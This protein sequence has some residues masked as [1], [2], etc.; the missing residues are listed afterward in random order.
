[1][2]ELIEKIANG[3]AILFVGAGFSASAINL[4][5]AKI[6]LAKEL[7]LEISK[8]GGFS[9]TDDLKVSSDYFINK[10]CKD[11]EFLMDE[12]INKLK[13]MY[14]IK[15][16]QEEHISILKLPW[17][18]IYTT[19][20]DDLVEIS[21]RKNN[22][23]IKTVTIDDSTQLNTN[24]NICVHLNGSI[25]SLSKDT[26]NTTFKL[27]SSSYL[28]PESFEKSNWNYIFKQ[29]IE[30]SSAIV[31]IGYSM[32]DIDIEKVLFQIPHLKNRTYFIRRD[33]KNSKNS[34]FEDFKFDKYGRSF[35]VG[36]SGF[37]K[38]V[39]ENMEKVISLQEQFFLESFSKYKIED[40]QVEQIREEDIEIFL[41][42]GNLKKEYIEQGMTDETIPFL[43]RRT[44]IEKLKILVNENKMICV[45]SELGNG[46]SVFLREAA[47]ELA[48]E[49]KQVYVLSDLSGNY[50]ADIDKI[51]SK[52]LS[53]ILIIDTYSNHPDIIKHLSIVDTGNVK[54]LF[55]E[56]TYRHY[57]FISDNSP[58]FKTKDLNIDIL[59]DSEI[60]KLIKIIEHT[61]LWGKYGKYSLGEKRRLLQDKLGSQISNVLIDIF[62]SKHIKDE[63]SKLLEKSI[64][65]NNKK[66][67]DVKKNIFITCLL[68]IMNIPISL[69]LVSDLSQNE[70]ILFTFSSTTEL[71]S[72]FALNLLEQEINTKSSVY[73]LHILKEHFEPNYIIEQCLSVLKDLDKKFSQGRI[74]DYNRNAVRINLFRFNFI[75]QILPNTTKR[76]ML[77]RYFENI[78]NILPYH[79]DNPQYWLQYAMAH[80]AM[81]NYE[82]AE[83]YL[84]TAY[85]KAKFKE[86]YDEYKIDNQ[87]ARL[88]LKKASIHSTTISDAMRLFI[89][90]DTL[91]N[92]L[93]NNI[94]KFKV[95]MDYK[96]FIDSRQK[97]FSHK[98]KTII[99][100]AC[101]IK[102]KDIE[103]LQK[104]DKNNFKQEKVYQQCKSWLEKIVED[105]GSI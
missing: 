19:N 21:S 70:E 48:L 22:K 57:Q 104:I 97:S 20:Y 55:S 75:E 12:L 92:K 53:C 26:L 5:D 16:P 42:Y 34:E 37:A 23:L 80:I 13:H 51:I 15:E 44:K 66:E 10:C 7:S 72:I 94:Y 90:A 31:F 76:E 81:N 96:D 29:D 54:F 25:S 88:N 27:T 60:E 43:I 98:N 86:F 69:S 83:R 38:I 3:R 65:K 50:I 85:D 73:S 45:T 89:E 82:K 105:L 61:T 9:E 91:L 67:E 74:L 49:G 33:N 2:N 4:Y 93:D 39:E 47:L 18:R 36:L 99:L 46:K 30:F 17:K 102:L 95:I 87:K 100:K 8:I 41:K 59:D 11:N 63:I 103:S 68:D 14:T 52:K 78:K 56:R 62:N 64:I 40:N 58:E 79:I 35:K 77:V 101:Q 6:P 1:M 84:Q 32:Y 71:R 28:S 24:D